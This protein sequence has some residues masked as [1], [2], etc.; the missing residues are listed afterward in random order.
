MTI[1]AIGGTS[2]A[3]V[4]QTLDPPQCVGIGWGCT[5]DW[6]F[7]LTISL[8]LAVIV[9]VLCVGA[10]AAIE[11]SRW[12]WPPERRRRVQSVLAKAIV[13]ILVVVLSLLAVNT[14]RMELIG[15]WV[16]R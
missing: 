15:G 11:L 3:Y 7:G 9:P 14:L 4:K 13:T 5:P 8:V 2:A 12:W 16:G 6:T 1:C 10:V